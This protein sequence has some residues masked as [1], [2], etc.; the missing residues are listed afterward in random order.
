MSVSLHFLAIDDEWELVLDWLRALPH[1]LA[2][3]PRENGQVVFFRDLGT[4]PLPPAQVDQSKTPLVWITTPRPLRGVLWTTGEVTFTPSPLRKLFPKLH[5]VS[6]AFQTWLQ[7]FPLVFSCRTP[8]AS[9]H[10]YYLEGQIQNR[11]LQ[12]YALPRAFA[13]L[14]NGQYFV[15]HDNTD[16]TVNDLCKALKLRAI[17][18]QPATS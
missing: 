18:V 16:R 4:L 2:W 11:D 1:D 6:K 15:H 13:A 9:E 10:L 17:A 7:Q 14:K 12:L 5:G 3:S 8:Q